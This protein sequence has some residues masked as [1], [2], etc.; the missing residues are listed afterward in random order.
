MASI[1]RR[2]HVDRD[3][4]EVFDAVADFSTT[5][6]WDPGVR[7]TRVVGAPPVGSGAQVEVRL[8]LGPVSPRLTYVTEVY[9]RPHR[10][11]LRAVSPVAV[12]VDDIRVEA[13]PEGGALVTWQADFDL[14]GPGRLLDPLLR[15]GFGSVADK[16]VV[17]L[18]AWLDAGGTADHR[19]AD[20]PRPT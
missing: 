18:E 14:R 10:V 2:I 3:P 4:T 5:A 7:A 16:A 11:V 9:E 6:Q 12:G 20:A 19:P 13:T 8:A 17:G 1:A 15:L